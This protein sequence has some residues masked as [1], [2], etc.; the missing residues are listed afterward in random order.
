M[1]QVQTTNLPLWI[2]CFCL[3]SLKVLNIANNHLKTVPA[4]IFMLQKLEY[5]SL[6]DNQVASINPAHIANNNPHIAS[7]NT[8]H[9]IEHTRIPG[10]C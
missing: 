9:H 3:Y 1:N 5:L 2:S 7:N 10:K 8:A 4:E 6:A